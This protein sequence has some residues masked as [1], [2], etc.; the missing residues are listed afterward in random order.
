MTA[1]CR[2]AGASPLHPVGIRPGGVIVVIKAPLAELT[3]VM[4]GNVAVSPHEKTELIAR[5]LWGRE[6][7]ATGGGRAEGRLSRMTEADQMSGTPPA[8]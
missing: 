6:I 5:G 2:E 7:F 8:R 1:Y 4:H 3:R